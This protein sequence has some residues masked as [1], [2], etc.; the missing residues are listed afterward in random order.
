MA[1]IATRHPDS[2]RRHTNGGKLD[3]Q[4]LQAF[5]ARPQEM[6]ATAQLLRAG[7]WSGEFDKLPAGDIDEDGVAEGRLLERRHYVRERTTKLRAEKINK[8]IAAYVRVHARSAGS[9]SSAPTAHAAPATRNATM[10]CRCTPR[11]RPPP[12][13]RTSSCCARTATA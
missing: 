3:Q 1:D 13:C 8:A 10:P 5:L 4:V 2:H 9:I 7:G 12:A 11:V 6:R